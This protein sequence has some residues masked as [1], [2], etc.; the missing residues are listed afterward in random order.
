MPF[1]NP[2][3]DDKRRPR[4]SGGLATLIQAEKLMQIA[5]LL[6]CATFVGWLLGAWADKALHTGWLGIAGIVF[7]GISGLVY[8]IRLV[9]STGTGDGKPPKPGSEL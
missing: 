7:G 5:L 8:V 3:P 6:P 9:M 1:N 4:D 2:I